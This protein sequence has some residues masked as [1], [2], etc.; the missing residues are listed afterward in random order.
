MIP[1]RKGATDRVAWLFVILMGS[2]TSVAAGVNFRQLGSGDEGDRFFVTVTHQPANARPIDATVTESPVQLREARH[3]IIPVD[4]VN[5]IPI[6]VREPSFVAIQTAG[7]WTMPRRLFLAP[8]NVDSVVTPRP[9]RE[10]PR[11]S[12]NL[13]TRERAAVNVLHE[14]RQLRSDNLLLKTEVAEL[15]RRPQ[16]TTDPRE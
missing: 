4:D 5:A 12:S 3:A 7:G 10:V 16:A 9:T 8:P 2:A 11:L 6:V 14:L 15:R 13:A 1:T